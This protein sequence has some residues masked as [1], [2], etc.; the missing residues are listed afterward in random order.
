MNHYFDFNG[1][2]KRQE[3]WAVTILTWVAVV[4]GSLMAPFNPIVA[5]VI[6]LVALWVW[7]ALSVRR[8]RDAG[9]NTWWI[10]TAFIPYVSFVTMIVFGCIK[11][12]ELG[13]AVVE[14]EVKVLEE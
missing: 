10:A 13:K 8:L 7:V 4:L 5:I 3:Y 12:E 6:L 14:D 2:A 9:L 1:T 11:S